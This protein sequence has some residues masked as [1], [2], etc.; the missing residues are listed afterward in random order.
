MISWLLC[1]PLR[2]GALAMAAI[3]IAV[4]RNARRAGSASKGN[5]LDFEYDPIFDGRDSRRGP[6]RSFRLLFFRPGAH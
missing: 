5:C 1:V 2:T 6:C 3:A 4:V